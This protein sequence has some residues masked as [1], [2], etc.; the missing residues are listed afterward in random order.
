MLPGEAHYTIAYLVTFVTQTTATQRPNSK[1]NL[2]EL[3]CRNT[4][5]E[6]TYGTL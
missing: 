2:L 1:Y 6:A 3:Y 5:P 4:E